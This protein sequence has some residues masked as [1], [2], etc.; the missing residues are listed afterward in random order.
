[1]LRSPGVCA[2]EAMLPD[3]P[4][5]GALGFLPLPALLRPILAPRVLACLPLTHII[6]VWFHRR[7]GLN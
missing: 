2:A 5:A 6:E 1:M 3:A 7:S 4:F